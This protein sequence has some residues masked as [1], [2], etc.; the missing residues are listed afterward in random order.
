MKQR[1]AY[2]LLVI[3]FVLALGLIGNNDYHDRME[4]LGYPVSK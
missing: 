1:I 3:L 4:E 2:A